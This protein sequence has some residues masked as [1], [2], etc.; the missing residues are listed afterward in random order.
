MGV[1]I[2]V[3]LIL[4]ILVQIKLEYP[5]FALQFV[6]ITIGQFNRNVIMERKMDVL[7]VWRLILAIPVEV[8]LVLFQHVLEFVGMGLDYPLKLVTIKT[9]LDAQLVVNQT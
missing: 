1:R 6:E 4:V 7:L 2:I 8:K 9:K 3:F 5:Q